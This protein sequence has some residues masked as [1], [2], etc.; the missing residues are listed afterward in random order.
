MSGPR[1]RRRL[2]GQR[3][4]PVKSENPAGSVHNKYAGRPDR[5]VIIIRAASDGTTPN[6]VHIHRR[7]THAVSQHASQIR[8]RRRRVGG[9]RVP[10]RGR[11]G[12]RRTRRTGRR[13]G[14]M[15]RRTVLGGVRA[16]EP[17]PVG[18]VVL[19]PGQ[20]RS[21]RRPVADQDRPRRRRP[22]RRRP[23]RA[24]RRRGRGARGTRPERGRTRG[25]N[26]GVHR[27]QG[28]A[29]LPGEDAALEPV[30]G[31]HRSVRDR[32]QRRRLHTAADQVQN[33]QLHRRRYVRSRAAAGSVVSGAH[34]ATRPLC[35]RP[36]NTT[37]PPRPGQT[38]KRNLVAAKPA[39][40]RI[41]AP[42]SVSIYR[43]GFSFF[44]FVYSFASAHVYIILNV[45]FSFQTT[46]MF[47]HLR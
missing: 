29:V 44:L 27:A 5:S 31:R 34:F 19:R 47:F 15:R 22:A 17:V 12:A 28:D 3:R 30:A 23:V 1:R 20:D 16:G 32:P 4:R 10:G 8:N 36:R 25:R 39:I 9:V 42:K 43:A 24:A 33:L 35:R 2:V 13:P 45:F 14:G 6:V 11:P 7:R 41:C 40:R 21:A 46:V 37:L 38:P 18:Q 26:R